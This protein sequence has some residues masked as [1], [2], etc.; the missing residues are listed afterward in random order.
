MIVFGI[1]I[2]PQKEYGMQSEADLDLIRQHDPDAL[3]L[4]AEGT[5]W[6]L[7]SQTY[8]RYICCVDPAVVAFAFDVA[9]RIGNQNIFAGAYILCAGAGWF[10]K[11]NP[12]QKIVLEKGYFFLL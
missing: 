10:E 12:R 5:R 6:L 3:R 11:T 1:E 4:V 2:L 8:L 7:S 9:D